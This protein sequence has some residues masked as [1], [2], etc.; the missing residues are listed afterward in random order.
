MGSICLRILAPLFFAIAVSGA[1]AQQQEA[2]RFPA[3]AMGFLGT[4]LPA[5]EKAIAN[6]DRAFFE[7]AMGR[8]LDFSESWG[9]KTHANPALARYPM[10]TEAVTDYLVVG[11]C[12]LRLSNDACEPV[13]A[14]NFNTNLQR[15][16]EVASRN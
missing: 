12:R 6:K 14:S 2:D 16:R 13:A 3:A 8:M 10:C 9:F 7:E 15:C 1:A 11:L 4:E 5:M